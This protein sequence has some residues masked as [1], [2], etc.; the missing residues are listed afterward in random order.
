MSL[1]G[2]EI[3]VF[4]H[5]PKC[6]GRS[7]FKFF[8]TIFGEDRVLNLYANHFEDENNKKLIE[9][10]NNC[11]LD[12][13]GYKAICGGHIDFLSHR[14]CFQDRKPVYVSLVREPLERFVSYFNY[15]SISDEEGKDLEGRFP[16]SN[17]PLVEMAK[18]C[19]DV[20][21]FYFEVLGKGDLP[22]NTSDVQAMFLTGTKACRI[23]N[24][25]DTVE[26]G[27]RLV[28]PLLMID[29]FCVRLAAEN[30]IEYT[31]APHQN[32]SIKRAVSADIRP[33]FR[34]YFC[35]RAAL[36]Y[37]TYYYIFTKA[38]VEEGKV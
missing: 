35:K 20:E 25:I 19:N 18:A 17:P 24:V 21:E 15:L 6:G 23:D 33:E 28:M 12:L 3:Y 9:D 36:D 22:W 7:I 13:T 32:F 11:T 4:I 14:D 34:E 27:Y 30:D 10:F 2:D 26:S 8:Q 1:V 16:S 5:I 29:K 37:F 38:L 31:R